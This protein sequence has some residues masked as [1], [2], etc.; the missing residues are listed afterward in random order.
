MHACSEM[1]PRGESRDLVE[2]VP[3]GRT[4]IQ[5]CAGVPDPEGVFAPGVAESVPAFFFFFFLRGIK[6]GGFMTALRS[7][8]Y[9]PQVRQR[10][11]GRS[12]LQKTVST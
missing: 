9:E 5:G 3:D 11:S 4:K 12:G 7:D 6:A 1:A 10:L 2:Y 8:R